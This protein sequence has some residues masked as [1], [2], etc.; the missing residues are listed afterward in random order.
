M[1]ELQLKVKGEY[2]VELF[3]KKNEGNEYTHELNKLLDL[4]LH[5]DQESGISLF[6]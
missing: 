2:R 6:K 4:A 3:S 1:I 5:M